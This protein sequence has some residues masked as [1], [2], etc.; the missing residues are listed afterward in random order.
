MMPSQPQTGKKHYTTAEEEE[1]QIELIVEI[2]LNP[3][4]RQGLTT[5]EIVSYIFDRQKQDPDYLDFVDSR[6][7]GTFNKAV[8]RLLD[9]MEKLFMLCRD[10]ITLRYTVDLRHPPFN[11]LSALRS[12]LG[13]RLMPKGLYQA[14]EETSHRMTVHAESAEEDADEAEDAARDA[15]TAKKLRMQRR[16]QRFQETYFGR[17]TRKFRRINHNSFGFH[18]YLLVKDKIYPILSDALLHETK[19]KLTYQT[20]SSENDQVI[21]F[22]PLGLVVFGPSVYLVGKYG[23]ENIH[24][25][26]RLL[27]SRIVDIEATSYPISEKMQKL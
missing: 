14:M 7:K 18:Q 3:Q 6:N 10:R 5:A 25:V 17:W 27:V 22:S 20:K 21:H 2:L 26:R 12:Q 16:L 4:H 24:D 13:Q 1:F 23:G 19:V 11:L 9:K 8:A 15:L